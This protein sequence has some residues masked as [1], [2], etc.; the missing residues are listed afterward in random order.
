MLSST[1][2]ISQLGDLRPRSFVKLPTSL[3]LWAFS[4]YLWDFD[5]TGR[6]LCGTSF[7][8]LSTVAEEDRSRCC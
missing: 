6:G 3:D 4:T 1:R 5:V 2:E 7:A 8:I